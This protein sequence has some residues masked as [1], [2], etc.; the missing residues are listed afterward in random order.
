MESGEEEEDNLS[1]SS[2]S[3]TEDEDFSVIPLLHT[4]QDMMVEMVEETDQTI[5][6]LRHLYKEIHH[7]QD[8][9]THLHLDDMITPYLTRWAEEKRLTDDGFH[10]MLTKKEQEEFGIT[11]AKT[12]IYTIC[13]KL[14]QQTTH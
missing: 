7:S 2:L 4:M 9:Y 1:I 12:T 8:L 11:N 14:I 10:I 13:E 5:D 6:T 3:S